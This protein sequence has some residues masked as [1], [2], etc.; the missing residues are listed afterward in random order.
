MGFLGGS[1]YAMAHQIS[2]GH[3]LVNERTWSRMKGPE[4]DTLTHEM[5]KL[6]RETRADQP[7]LDDT[8]ALQQR[9]RKISRINTA[10]NM[11]KSFRMR[12]KL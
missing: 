12:R 11:L 4:F 10:L 3:I 7:D 8:L 5:Q 9:N 6:L 1:A 2:E